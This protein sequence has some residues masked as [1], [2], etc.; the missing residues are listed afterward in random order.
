MQSGVNNNQ[1]QFIWGDARANFKTGT[2]K[3]TKGK[4]FWHKW[5]CLKR[6]WQARI[7]HIVIP[8][9]AAPLRT[10]SSIPTP[11]P[12]HNHPNL[13]FC[14]F[15]QFFKQMERHDSLFYVGRKSF[16]NC[17]VLFS[18]CFVCIGCTFLSNYS[19]TS[20]FCHY[21]ST[22]IIIGEV[23]GWRVEIEAGILL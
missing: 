13:F 23:G 1:S 17:S 19:R 3:Q 21:F 8:P 14:C 15:C 2:N 6:L 22:V 9:T 10:R 16:P 12:W 4:R 20:N 18:P 5:E 7:K 11:T